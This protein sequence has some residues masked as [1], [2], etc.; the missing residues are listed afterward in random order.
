MRRLHRLL[1]HGNQPL[2]QFC[3]LYLTV[4][5]R[6][7]LRN[8]ATRLVLLPIEPPINRLLETTA[9]RPEERGG[10]QGRSDQDHW[11]GGYLRAE[12][13]EHKLRA[14]DE[15]RI[16]QDQQSGEQ[17][18]DQRAPDEQID[19]EGIGIDDRQQEARDIDATAKE[20]GEGHE[21]E[22]E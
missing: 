12:E 2:A 19:I 11:R 18:I 6:A 22:H 17:C 13:R 15:P 4:Q 20:A 10:D 8:D 16:G 14:R 7:E 3:Q 5:A 9:Q 21:D 1:H